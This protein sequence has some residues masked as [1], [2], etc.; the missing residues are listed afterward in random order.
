M[1][2]PDRDNIPPSPR[3]ADGTPSISDRMRAQSTFERTPATRNVTM[4]ASGSS[5]AETIVLS[6]AIVTP[7]NKELA[8]VLSSHASLIRYD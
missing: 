4:D 6:L 1:F 7:G 2:S 5:L 3:R 8:A